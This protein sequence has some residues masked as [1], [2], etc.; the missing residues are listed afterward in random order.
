MGFLSLVVAFIF[1]A[2]LYE[3]S[4]FTLLDWQYWYFMA[5][6]FCFA[7]LTSDWED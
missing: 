7:M 6:F 5:L 2:S 1:G 3:V 4:G